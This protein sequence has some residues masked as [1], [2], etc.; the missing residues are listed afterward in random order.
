MVPLNTWTATLGAIALTLGGAPALAAPVAGPLAVETAPASGSLAPMA[1]ALETT[2]HTYADLFSIAFPAG[3]QV[4]EPTEGPQVVAASPG[5]QGPLP[6]M[7]TEIT[8]HNAPPRQVVGTSLQAIQTKGYAVTRY[9]AA[10]IDGVTAVRLWMSEIPDDL[11][12]AFV[13]FVGYP[14]ATAIITTFYGD[15]DTDI[16]P[17][18]EEIHRSFGRSR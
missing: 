8:W 1:P 18:L 7:R 2:P 16:N 9:D 15:T 3:W 17:V 12:N 11:P 14:D 4:S 10:N 13:T 6:A 5:P